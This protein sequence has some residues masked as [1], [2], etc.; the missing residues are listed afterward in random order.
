MKYL[1]KRQ[2]TRRVQLF[3][4]FGKISYPISTEGLNVNVDLDLC[5]EIG[6][7]DL[8]TTSSNKK[9]IL[10]TKTIANGVYKSKHYHQLQQQQLPQQPPD[11]T[12]CHQRGFQFRFGSSSFSQNSETASTNHFK[13]TQLPKR[14]TMS[15]SRDVSVHELLSLLAMTTPYKELESL[16]LSMLHNTAFEPLCTGNPTAGNIPC[17]KFW[18][19][20]FEITYFNSNETKHQPHQ[21]A[22]IIPQSALNPIG[23]EA[24]CKNQMQQQQQQK[25]FQP[26]MNDDLWLLQQYNRNIIHPSPN[27]I[28]D[29]TKCIWNRSIQWDNCQ[30][31]TQQH[32]EFSWGRRSRAALAHQQHTLIAAVPE[33][34]QHNQQMITPAVAAA[35]SN[36]KYIVRSNDTSR[37][38]YKNHDNYNARNNNSRLQYQQQHVRHS[39]QNAQQQPSSQLQQ[40]QYWLSKPRPQFHTSRFNKGKHCKHCCCNVRNSN[41]NNNNYSNSNIDPYILNLCQEDLYAIHATGV[42]PIR[43]PIDNWE[44]TMKAKP[45]GQVTVPM[46]VGCNLYTANFPPLPAPNQRRDD[47]FQYQQD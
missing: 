12:T 38:F 4:R 5:S 33:Y 43:K 24:K 1:T 25:Q 36:D 41:H 44:I 20:P 35:T 34:P 6:S 13:L 32:R 14:R 29:S 31:K 3:N 37:Y 46:G 39:Y 17:K 18:S 40:Q 15:W 47:Q 7:N 22:D 10:T 16:M 27:S 30:Q 9:L 42:K 21:F 19:N 11:G 23:Y 45:Q 26:M 28:V 8:E 2:R